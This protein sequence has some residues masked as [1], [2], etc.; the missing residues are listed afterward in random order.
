M[1]GVDTWSPL[2]DTLKLSSYEITKTGRIRRKKNHLELKPYLVAGYWRVNLT[3]DD[4]SRPKMLVHRLVASAFLPNPEDHPTVD[5]IDRN[6]DNNALT[7]LRWASRSLQSQNKTHSYSRGNQVKQLDLKRN[8]V[9]Q[10]KS[11][12]AAARALNFPI[13][14]IGKRVRNKC[15]YRGFF[16]ERVQIPHKSDFVRAL[17]PEADG[18]TTELDMEVNQEGLFRK[19][20]GE[21][22]Y[23]SIDSNGYYV[24]GCGG[25]TIR[26]HRVV[27]RT[28]HGAPR[29]GV[30][31]VN[32]INTI[33]SDNRVAN[34]EW[35]TTRQN[36]MHSAEN[37]HFKSG[38]VTA[39]AQY[40]LEGKLVAVHD[41]MA[42]A[43]RA[44]GIKSNRISSVI[45]GKN[46]RVHEWVFKPKLA[47][48]EPPGQIPPYKRSNGRGRPIEQ[49]SK[50]G[51]LMQ[52]F[53]SVIA[54][55]DAAGVTDST[56]R[57]AIRERK[58][59]Y[60]DYVY[61][62]VATEPSG[63][64]NNESDSEEVPDQ[65]AADDSS[66][67]DDQVD[68]QMVTDDLSV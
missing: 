22:T 9:A 57:T 58:G 30:D 11:Y 54:A 56:I 25:Q 44:T 68:Q 29:P 36:I 16:F 65:E 28:F 7:N 20:D 67:F 12:A 55:A 62:H 60:G 51:K 6:K 23:G 18:S 26:A 61:R 41:S 39:V 2:P 33:R 27:C 42:A 35:V 40:S 15:S 48:V 10:F 50:E 4:R 49:Y 46:V 53:K 38:R 37:I 17:K 21:T 8:L 31:V 5:H 14:S 13:N 3:A 52:T 45:K 19:S 59:H 1:T 24:I 63:E 64:T 32:H 66:T 34:L 43:S 47:D